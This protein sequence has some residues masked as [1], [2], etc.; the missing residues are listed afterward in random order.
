MANKRRS[1]LVGGVFQKF[2]NAEVNVEVFCSCSSRSLPDWVIDLH[3]TGR[4]A[5]QNTVSSCSAIF[6]DLSWT[7]EA[8]DVH[9]A[10]FATGKN[11]RLCISTKCPTVTDHCWSTRRRYVI[12]TCN[13]N[14]K[15]ENMTQT[16]VTAAVRLEGRVSVLNRPRARP[17]ARVSV[18]NRP[19]FYS[20]LIFLLLEQPIPLSQ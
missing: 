12:K 8:K 2:L 17:G 7:G 11:F 1:K 5:S 13:K 6:T 4:A 14:L 9:E 19:L 15:K 20:Y 10:I 3:N 18:L 16:L